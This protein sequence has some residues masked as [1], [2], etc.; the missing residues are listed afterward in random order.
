MAIP[1]SPY[2]SHEKH[3]TASG[4]AAGFGFMAFVDFRA[5]CGDVFW[6]GGGRQAF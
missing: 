6:G 2:D 3:K 4:I 1:I 5:F